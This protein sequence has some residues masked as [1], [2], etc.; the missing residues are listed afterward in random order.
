MIVE[1]NLAFNYF[2]LANKLRFLYDIIN[3]WQ[4]DPYILFKKMLH[5]Y[6]AELKKKCT[7][8]EKKIDMLIHINDGAYSGQFFPP[9]LKGNNTPPALKKLL[10]LKVTFLWQICMLGPI[11]GCQGWKHATNFTSHKSDTMRCYIL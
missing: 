5:T 7:C 1:L 11:R 3:D 4:R 9:S 2:I 10:I 8:S 6:F